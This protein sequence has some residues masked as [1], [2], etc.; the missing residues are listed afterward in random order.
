MRRASGKSVKRREN[1]KYDGS[2]LEYFTFSQKLIDR[3]VHS[4]L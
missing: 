3:E 1:G 2:H 4:C